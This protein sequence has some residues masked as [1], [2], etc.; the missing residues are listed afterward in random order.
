MSRS[1]STDRRIARRQRGDALLEALI[2]SVLVAL[3]VLGSTY[4]ATRVALSQSHARTQA[5]AIAQLR[6]LLQET[7]DTSPWCLGASPPAI[8][9]R[10]ADA[11]LAPVDLPVTATCTTPT[12]ITLGGLTIS[13]PSRIRLSVSSPRLF[14]GVGT[15]VVG[16]SGA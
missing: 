1:R 10:P 15:L 14:G 12:G 5:M 7:A 4:T 9:L 11:S 6:N 3:L 8:R 2:G 13:A 16:D